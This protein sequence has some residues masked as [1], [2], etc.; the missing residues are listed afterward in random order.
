M[1]QVKR[2]W[3]WLKSLLSKLFGHSEDQASVESGTI[4]PEQRPSRNFPRWR[5]NMPKYQPC[6]FGCGWKRR[7]EKTMGGAKYWCN[8]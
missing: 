3:T 4:S 1:Q 5:H 7:L 2:F 6:P 8:Q